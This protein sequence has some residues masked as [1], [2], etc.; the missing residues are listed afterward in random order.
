M[1][2]NYVEP[3]SQ[4]TSVGASGVLVT[5][6]PTAGQLAKAITR[7][8]VKPDPANAHTTTYFDVEVTNDSAVISANPNPARSVAKFFDASTPNGVDVQGSF[9]YEG[10]DGDGNVYVRIKPQPDQGSL[11]TQTSAY[12][13]RIY[14]G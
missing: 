13:V 14:F 6:T 12:K 9:K 3:A 8:M 1:A 10:T 4:P 5:L 7:I 11:F 2:T